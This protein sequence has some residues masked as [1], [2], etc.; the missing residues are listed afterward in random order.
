MNNM[1]DKKPFLSVDQWESLF[2]NIEVPAMLLN[3]K[4][5][6]I[7]INDSM[8]NVLKLK[9]APIGEKCYKIVHGT[10]EPIENCPHSKSLK[11]KMTNVEKIEFPDLNAWFLV[12]TGP[13]SDS[14]NINVY[15]HIGQDITDLINT[16]NELEKSVEFK[17]LLMKETHHRVKN[18]FMSMSSLLFI[19]SLN[20][21]D[22]SAKSAL[23]DAQNRVKSMAITHQTIY[24]RENF[25]K[26]ELKYYFKQLLDELLKDH[27]NENIT[28]LLDVDYVLME[29]NK[30][31]VLGLILTELVSNSLKY[32]FSEDDMGIIQVK[33]V[34][35]DDKY[36]FEVSD[37]GNQEKII[38]LNDDDIVNSE[39]FGL[40]MVKLLTKQ[41]NGEISV[42]YLD[43]T[44]FT[45]IF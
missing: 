32:A 41:L 19:Q 39:S 29:S 30:A 34:E 27:H 42:K 9:E 15:S 38:D 14:E 44:I 12:T 18:N 3:D 11:T 31:L 13:I 35:N 20:A 43:G 22:S 26:I 40:S 8:K 7:R 4:H 33:F 1:L 45:I 5:E 21:Q 6:I 36:I 2:E 25:E 23:M 17:E 10:T 24:S 37:N 28:Y 16:K